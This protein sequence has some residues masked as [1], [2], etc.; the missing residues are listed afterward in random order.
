MSFLNPYFLIGLAAIAVPI[1]IHLLTRDRVRRVAFST[2][3]FFQ[4][5]SRKVLRRKRFREMILLAMR[6][7]AC[8]LLAVA[9]ARPI[10]RATGA[11]EVGGA[12]V[13]TARVI[14]V[15]TSASMN[16]PGL[17][18]AMRAAAGEA[19]S[20]LSDGTDAAAL[21]AFDRA[22]RVEVPLPPA[23]AANT[24]GGSMGV[25]AVRE[26]VRTIV[27]GDGGTDIVAA[28]RK[29]DSDL[30]SYPA[31]RK[32]IVLISDFQRIGWRNFRGD[33]KLAADTR[34][35]PKSVASAVPPPDLAIVEA[36]YPASTTLDGIPRT[37][38]VRV[39]NYSTEERRDVE[40]ALTV[41]GRKVDSQ[42][43]QIRAG[44]SV[45]IRF[46]HVFTTP[47]N[48]PGTVAVA[49]TD[50]A[51]ENNVYYFNARVIPRIKVALVTGRPAGPV[52][53]MAGDG[54]VGGQAPE[55]AFFIERAL[56]PTPDSP[57]I[58]RRIAAA[59]AAA[60]DLKDAL[61][62]ILSDVRDLSPSLV[63]VL[64]SRLKS[65]GIGIFFLP[66][67]QVQ[68]D[69]F[70]RA[71]SAIA[72]CK[73]KGIALP[74]ARAGEVPGAALAQVDFEHPIFEVFQHPHYGDLA[75]PR[76]KKYWEVT[77]SQLARVL[78]RFDDGR[79]AVLQRDIDAGVSMLFAG[80]MDLRWNNFP[81]RA[82]F[83]PFMHQTV[84]YLAVRTEKKT[85]YQVGDALPAPEGARVTDPKGEVRDG[86]GLVAAIPGFYVVAATD[87]GETFQ[88][89]ANL[90]PA[91]SDPAVIPPE[92]VVAAVQ[93]A[94][95]A[96]VEAREAAE[97]A[98]GDGRDDHGFWW[99][100]VLAVS[101]L[102]ISELFVANKTLR[103]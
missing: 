75:L 43:V 61:V 93:E 66:G 101:I 39:A 11:D 100:I 6:A 45:P 26:K 71:F 46:R 34:L 48:N 83:L 31:R 91:E 17:A 94:E 88:F 55:P 59:Q 35:V 1:V 62:V 3:R 9:F 70:N 4:K 69:D 13:S 92:E 30:R 73:L 41:G 95:G 72:P 24:E 38:A 77:D 67:Q 29:A 57:F 42:K 58:V 89:A 25:S 27:P 56:A 33:W 20:G 37:V 14:L 99:Y 36:D 63:G 40:V 85:G 50:A 86:T 98:A 81:L 53:L 28:I 49:G 78:A 7:A 12:A 97:A 74:A 19:I 68:A 44:E 54:T 10:L 8:G 82:V 16:R 32:E 64:A 90:D 15:D 80:P 22:A 76:F 103:H 79:P 87:G 96:I 21:I 18:D 102:V 65:P 84:R 52:I 2:L 60:D 47:G 51:P 5:V 23:S